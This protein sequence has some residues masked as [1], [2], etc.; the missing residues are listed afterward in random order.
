MN[1]KDISHRKLN[2]QQ[3]SVLE[4]LLNFRFST[5]KQIAT[6]LERSGHKSIQNKLKILEARSLI[7]KRYDKTYRLAGRQAEYYLTPKGAKQLESQRPETVH[8]KALM[9][10]YRNK[11]ASQDFLHHCL[12][13]ADVALKLR[14]L[15]NTGDKK[16]AAHTAAV[17]Y[18]YKYLPSWLPDLLIVFET[19]SGTQRAFVDVW[20]GSRPFFVSVRKMRSHITFLD[21]GDWPLKVAAA[22]ALLTVCADTHSQK[23]LNRQIKK[24]LQEA[25]GT[26]GARCATTT[27]AQL[28]QSDKLNE[29]LWLRISPDDPPQPAS[30]RSIY[31]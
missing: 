27:L 18:K 28:T 5:C 29:K 21:K 6:H 9:A 3:L 30:L 25:Y 13:V 24:A 7:T 19:S 22:P 31:K 10:L 4:W 8:R 1:K 14:T 26:D 15:H 23:K 11:M 12:A 2:K 20:E 17:L 16:F